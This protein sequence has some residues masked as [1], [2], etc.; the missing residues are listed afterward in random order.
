MTTLKAEKRDL[1]V[2]PKKLR[3]EGF[4]TGSIF[5][6][7]IDGSVPV[8]MNAH[9]TELALRT[10]GKGSRVVIDLDGDKK[11]VLIKEIQKYPLKNQLIEIDFQELV[12][13]EMVNSIAAVVLEN[14]SSVK[15]GIAELVEKEIHYSALPDSIVDKVVVD[16]TG[17]KVGDAIKVGDL[18][19]AKDKNI[20]IKSDLDAVIVNVIM[21][22]ETAEDIAADAAAAD[23]E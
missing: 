2:K 10:V 21:A 13:G 3:R 18:D 16:C 15:E 8:M 7:D 19:L 9:D 5:G 23:A 22:K 4:V 1:S 12:K 20:K 17:L 6:K 11:N 14:E